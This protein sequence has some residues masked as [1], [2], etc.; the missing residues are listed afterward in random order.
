MHSTSGRRSGR[1]GA[2]FFALKE[3]LRVDQGSETKKTEVTQSCIV[4]VLAWGLG[5]L[6][7]LQAERDMLDGAWCSILALI[8]RNRASRG[9]PYVVRSVLHRR[10]IRD[11]LIRSDPKAF[12]SSPSYRYFQAKTS[13]AAK[14]TTATYPE[15]ESYRDL[16]AVI[17]WRSRHAWESSRRTRGR[18]QHRRAGRVQSWED[19]L[20][21]EFS[22]FGEPWF[23]RAPEA[24]SQ[25]AVAPRIM[26]ATRRKQTRKT[27]AQ[28][29]A[30][31]QRRFTPHLVAPAEAE[32]S[33][34]DL[35][36]DALP[37]DRCPEGALA[38]VASRPM[39]LAPP[40]GGHGEWQVLPLCGGWLRW[41]AVVGRGDLHC[42]VHLGKPE[43]KMDRAL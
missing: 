24:F 16:K 32:A 29:V 34:A 10:A 38:E 15:T 5:S 22:T 4:P 2:R 40:T 18:A 7:L 36:P 28:L 25:T 9:F 35:P 8:I 23:Q 43:C 1:P 11:R 17:E 13:I 41:S 19:W 3:Q 26:A 33:P 37:G 12:I 14:V 31:Y 6:S 30:D 42:S 21:G 39:V 27:E 20:D